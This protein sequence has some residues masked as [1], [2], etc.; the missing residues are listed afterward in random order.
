MSLIP[1]AFAE[2]T[3][4]V[5]SGPMSNLMQFLPMVVIFALFWFLLIR[6]QQ[7][8]MKLHN[9]MLASLDKGSEVITNGGLLGTIIE[10]DQQYVKLK[11]ADGVV[12]KFQRSAIAGK[13]DKTTP[14]ATNK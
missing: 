3:S 7:K 14:V 8:K 4:A 11:I 9:Q 6:P 13:L 12:A 10:L 1:Q 5:A 2:G